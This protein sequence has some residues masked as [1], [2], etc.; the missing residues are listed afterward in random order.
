MAKAVLLHITSSACEFQIPNI[1]S[2]IWAQ[3]ASAT[4]AKREKQHFIGR[5]LLMSCFAPLMLEMS[6]QPAAG[7]YGVSVL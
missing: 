1:N 3:I 5:Y 6:D 7:F 2:A 4:P